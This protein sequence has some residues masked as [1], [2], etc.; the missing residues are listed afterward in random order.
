MEFLYRWWGFT[1]F[2]LLFITACGGGGGGSSQEIKEIEELDIFPLEVGASYQYGSADT[3]SVGAPSNIVGY[4]AYPLTHSTG[5]KE[6]FSTHSGKLL[7]LGV[8]VPNVEVYTTN[9]V[10]KYTAD[11]RLDAPLAVYSDQW[12]AGHDQAISGT[13]S[14]NIQPGYGKRNFSYSGS[15]TYYGEEQVSVP[16]GQYTAHHIYFGLNLSI[17]ID[18]YMF[19]VPISSHLW[20]VDGIG[21]V[22]R[23]ENGALF[24]LSDIEG[25]PERLRFSTVS[26]APQLPVSEVVRLDGV[27]VRA[28]QY[29]YSIDTQGSPV[30]WL[31]VQAAQNV[32]NAAVTTTAMAPGE[33]L[34][35]INLTPIGGGSALPVEV[36]Y[37]VDAPTIDVPAQLVFDLRYAQTLGDFSQTLSFTPDGALQAWSASASADWMMLTE[38][39]G[40]PWNPAVEVALSPQALIGKATSLNETITL[41]YQGEHSA[42]GTAKVAVQ[43][44]LPAGGLQIPATAFSAASGSPEDFEVKVVELFGKPITESE[45]QVSV[46]YEG[47]RNGWLQV[48]VNPQSGIYEFDILHA[49]LPPDSYRADVTFT[50]ANGVA[51]Q[52]QVT[53]ELAE[54]TIEIV[55][56]ASWV[57]DSSTLEEALRKTLTFNHTGELLDWEISSP[58]PWLS[59]QQ[60]ANGFASGGVAELLLDKASLASLKNG[61][62]ETELTVT[63]S[64]Q[65]VSRKSV[66]VPVSVSINFPEIRYAL[67][68]VL[69]DTQAAQTIDVTGSGLQAAAGQHVTIGAVVADEVSIL[70][71]GR[72]QARFPALP[73]GEAQLRIGNALGV[74]RPGAR[75]VVKSA[76]SY[77]QTVVPVPGRVESMAYDP[78]RDA[79]YGVFWNL[80]YTSG[81]TIQRI[82]YVN[83]AW[84]M[85]SIPVANPVAL[86]LLPDGSE[87]LVTTGDCK[88]I[89]VDPDT[90]A[91]S[92]P[93]AGN[94]NCYYATYGTVAAFNDGQILVANTNQWP[95]VWEYPG[96]VRTSYPSIYNPRTM[97]SRKRNRMIYT[98]SPSI[99]G[100]REAYYYDAHN[101]SY[102]PFGV[103]REGTY[104][105]PY[106]MSLSADGSRFSHFNDIYDKNMLHLG[107]LEGYTDADLNGDIWQLTPDG[108]RVIA[109]DFA[110]NTLA[111]FDVTAGSGPYPKLGADIAMPAN[112]VEQAFTIEPSID[113][114]TA[115][116]FGW[117]QGASG[118]YMVV[119]D[120]YP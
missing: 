16:L 106:L 82:R 73:L 50:P 13:G 35:T 57:I 96:F 118:F 25:L 80:N 98:E 27:A 22:Q 43:I 77:A 28:D 29:S 111:V 108:R 12:T 48:A 74:D 76:P 103:V 3:V 11:V 9:G 110:T 66:S 112:S 92:Q 97:V 99:S 7:Y 62:Y 64:G 58:V 5:A 32:L 30:E 120:L 19:E 51:L 90:L 104:F 109:H 67:P 63:Y 81:Y 69:Y 70:D 72:L 56:E 54:P 89:H 18:G 33:Y 60:V 94:G 41:H 37:Q 52:A 61:V 83:S 31:S 1:L 116:I 39:H 24:Y 95:T 40:D 113:G 71:D 47:A 87:L 79:F 10:Y 75:F 93:H 20:L 46:A 86:T 6:Y 45:Y 55:G 23:Q 14:A 102:M 4:E 88:V 8:F 85:D 34:A 119:Q 114:E 26:G 105:L 101:D 84:V 21:I 42:A 100:P 17:S 2:V 107:S 15:V 59:A 115:F 68:Y 65:Y 38:Q 44:L 36:I 49:D 117:K 78:E 53:F 91:T